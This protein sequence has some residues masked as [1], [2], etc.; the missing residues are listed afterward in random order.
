MSL[1]RYRKEIDERTKEGDDGWDSGKAA[2]DGG[3]G[4]HRPGVSC[5]N[6]EGLGRRQGQ[7]GRERGLGRRRWRG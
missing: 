3:P 2:A 1:R 7:R 4:S 5:D 6:G